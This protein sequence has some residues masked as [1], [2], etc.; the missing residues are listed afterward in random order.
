MLFLLLRTACRI[1]LLPN[2][3][4][5]TPKLRRVVVI[6]PYGHESDSSKSEHVVFKIT[7]NEDEDYVLD[8]AGAQF[9]FYDPLTPW[10]SYQHNRIKKLGEIRPL[11]DLRDSH[12]LLGKDLSRMKSGNITRKALNGQFA[13]IFGLALKSWQE[14]NGGFPALLKLR[15]NIFCEKQGELLDSIDERV[16]ASMKLLQEAK[17]RI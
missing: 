3:D 2:E 5:L 1:V 15:E 13:E 6:E 16:C 8:V 11:K 14:K 17:D 7:I 10:V 4:L 12:R 9:G